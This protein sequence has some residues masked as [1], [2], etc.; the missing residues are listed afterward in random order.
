MQGLLED[1]NSGL[2]LVIKTT[3]FMTDIN[4]YGDINEAY[5]VYFG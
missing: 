3:V 2:D 5:D 1:N 4:D